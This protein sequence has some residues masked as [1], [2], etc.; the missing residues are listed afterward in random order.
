VYPDDVLS[1]LGPVLNHRVVVHP[2]FLIRGETVEAVIER[3]RT[4]V[5]PPSR[6]KATTG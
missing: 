1:V 3:V 6:S 4:A 5:K 2:D